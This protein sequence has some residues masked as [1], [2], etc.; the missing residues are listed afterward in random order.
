MARRPTVIDLFCGAGGFSLGFQAAGCEIV[1]AVDRDEAAGQTFTANFG[2]L[3]DPAPHGFFGPEKGDL[4]SLDLNEIPVKE[5][6]DILIGSPP[7]QGFSQIG[8]GKLGSLNEAGFANDPRNSLFKRFLD[9]ARLW[10]PRVLVMENV[11]GMYSVQGENVASEVAGAMSRTGVGYRVGYGL[12]N[13][14]WYGV[15]QFRERIFFIGIREDLGLWPEF[16][17]QACR[18]HLPPGYLDTGASFGRQLNLYELLPRELSPAAAPDDA[19]EETT[20]E[21]A[22]GDLPS[23]EES[24]AGPLEYQGPP[25]CDFAALMRAWPGFERVNGVSDNEI[26]QTPRDTEIFRRMR[27][28]D[29]YPDALRI[30][31]NLLKKARSAT[32]SVS[33]NDL[34]RQI[35][36]PYPEDSFVDKWRKLIPNR[37]SWTVTAHLGKDTYSHIHYDSNQARMIS[38]RETARL[39]SFP[40][41]FILKGNMGERWRQIG[42]AVPPLVAWRIACKLLEVLATPFTAPEYHQESPLRP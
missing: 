30:A 21:A 23:L 17:Q 24:V 5:P 34:E 31:R 15:P 11:R 33:G 22:L 14:A 35:V 9:A 27:P 19:P 29:R 32:N 12:L 28:G 25:R 10:Q 37:P 1:A 40:D 6:L 39:Q 36:P 41:A 13:A 20:S 2:R 8:R 18:V 26:R 7:C 16:P 4:A 3:Q 38:I 42:N